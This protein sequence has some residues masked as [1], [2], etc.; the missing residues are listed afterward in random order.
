MWEGL[1]NT[2]LEIDGE[3]C[4]NLKEEEFKYKKKHEDTCQQTP[5]PHV[6]RKEKTNFIYID[7]CI[8]TRRSSITK[9]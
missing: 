8:S 7:R 9:E 4:N 2:Q 5:L 6:I 3:N 1:D